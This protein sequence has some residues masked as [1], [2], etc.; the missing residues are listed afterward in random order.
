MFLVTGATGAQGGAVA[1]SLLRQALPVRLLVRDLQSPAAAK[2]AALGAELALGAFENPA[3]LRAAMEGVQ[4][5]FS[6]QLYNP[7]QPETETLAARALI[8]A[9]KA[10]GV[11]C[12]V[13]TSVSGADILGSMPGWAEGRWDKAYWENKDRVEKDA[14]EAGFAS[15]IVLRPAFMMENF[16]PPKSRW[17]FPDCAAGFLRTATAPNTSIALVAAD[18]IGT[19]AALAFSGAASF[20]TL[21]LAG[22][23]LSFPEIAA[24]LSAAWGRKIVSETRTPEALVAAGQSPGWVVTQQWLNEVGYPARPADAKKFGLSLASLANWAGQ[25]QA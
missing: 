24:V 23:L 10:A 12:F 25:H 9:A 5:V 1:R 2:L 8:A 14:L 16:I 19:A 7:K 17:M 3:S 4:G 21:E 11:E 22:D 18:D 6:V 20:T 15:A 13:Q